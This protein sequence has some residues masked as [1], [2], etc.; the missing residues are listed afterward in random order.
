MKSE[1]LIYNG[2]TTCEGCAMEIVARTMMKVF[3]HRS[4]L[5]TPPSCSAILTG[6][7]RETGWK[8]P[9]FQSN[10]ENI[11]A[12]MSGMRAGLD[13]Q[14]KK[15]IFI[16]GLAGDGGTVDI[17]LQAL[18]GAVERGHRFIYVCYDNEAYMNTGIQR[19]GSTPRNAWTTTTPGGKKEDKKDIVGMLLA[20]GIPYIA[21]A[22]AGYVDDLARKLEK[23]KDVEGPSYI[24]VSAPCSTGWRF[25]AAD[26]VTISRLAVN[27]GL[28]PLFEATDGI[29]HVTRK[30]SNLEPLEVFVKKQ[31]RFSKMSKE[32]LA[33]WQEETVDKYN[34]LLAKEGLRWN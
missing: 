22:S 7:G 34:R 1:S 33:K 31:G 28:W 26:T 24:H 29:I 25:P 6:F 15:D 18:S 8:V 21:T 20:Q 2:L 30:V 11:A 14:G 17:G 10:L 9:S 12:Y 5:L 4:I 27:S 13:I 32:D 3:G 19:S 16:V 23:A